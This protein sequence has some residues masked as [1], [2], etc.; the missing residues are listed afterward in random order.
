MRSGHTQ[1]ESHPK[2]GCR[3]GA[4]NPSHGPFGKKQYLDP[5]KGV[6]S[7]A[8]R[9]FPNMFFSGP[10]EDKSETGGAKWA[11]IQILHP[12]RLTWNLTINPWKRKI[13]FQTIIFRFYVTEMHPTRISEVSPPLERKIIKI[14]KIA[15][16]GGILILRKVSLYHHFETFPSFKTVSISSKPRVSRT[17]SPHD[18]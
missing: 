15:F 5:A 18:S 10:S 8:A 12:G 3:L 9:T 13:I 4:L 7:A 17:T 2:E 14:F 11:S 16:L 1:T 6:P